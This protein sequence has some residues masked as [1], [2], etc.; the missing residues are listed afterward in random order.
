M[1]YF[2]SVAID[3]YLTSPINDRRRVLQGDSLSPLLFNLIANTLITTIKEEKLKCMSYVYDGGTQPKHWMPF[4]NDT[5][6][7]LSTLCGCS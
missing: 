3:N 4:A 1:G 5:T 7:V 2:I 6:I